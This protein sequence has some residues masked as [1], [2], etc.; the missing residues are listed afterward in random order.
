MKRQGTDNW[1]GLQ[2]QFASRILICQIEETSKIHLLT[3]KTNDRNWHTGDRQPAFLCVLRASASCVGS[4][5]SCICA[6]KIPD[7]QV[8]VLQRFGY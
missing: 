5:L 6:V 3:A 2:P 8:K 4:L 1:I 7:N